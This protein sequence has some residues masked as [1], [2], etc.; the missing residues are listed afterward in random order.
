MPS[1]GGQHV[2]AVCTHK[3]ATGAGRN[4]AMINDHDPPSSFTF[5][6]RAPPYRLPFDI[7]HVL[8][9]RYGKRTRHTEHTTHVSYTTLR[10]PIAKGLSNLS[11]RCPPRRCESTL[12][13]GPTIERSPPPRL[14]LPVRRESRPRR[15]G[16]PRVLSRKNKRQKQKTTNHH[17][18][19]IIY[20][21]SNKQRPKRTNNFISN[22]ITQISN[23]P[24]PRRTIRPCR[25]KV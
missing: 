9:M 4:R 20:D 8:R 21:D 22:R 10:Q 16:R 17:S 3:A 24:R 5:P 12:S 2:C 1:L 6:P 25:Q 14:Y 11:P 13:I 15:L 18:T 7:A 23:D 19:I